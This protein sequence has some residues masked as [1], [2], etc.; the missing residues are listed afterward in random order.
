MSG[1]AIVSGAAPHALAAEWALRVGEA[2]EALQRLRREAAARAAHLGVPTPKLEAWKYT[3]LAAL[4]RTAW[5]AVVRLE[6]AGCPS[7]AVA[8]GAPDLTGTAPLFPE[9]VRV[10]SLARAFADDAD[11]VLAHLAQVASFADDYVAALN[12]AFLHDGIWIDVAPGVQ[13]DGAL[14]VVHRAPEGDAAPMT[15]GRVLITAGAGSSVAVC[16]RFVSDGAGAAFTTGVTEI[17]CG[18]NAQVEHT[19][20]VSENT[21]TI[22]LG[23]VAAR[24]ARDSRLISHAVSTGGALTRVE[25]ASRLAEPGAEATFNGLYLG[26][27]EQHVD[28]HTTLDHAA[29]HCTSAQTYRGVL[30]GRAHGVFNGAVIVRPD[31][32]K[33]DARQSNK[34]LLLSST[35]AIDTK[36]QLEIFANDVKCT[37]GATVGS[38]DEESLFYL[39]SRGI[40]RREAETLL[41]LAFANDIVQRISNEL[42]RELLAHALEAAFHGMDAAGDT[43]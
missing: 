4:G 36:P 39:R 18:A 16:E 31:A 21:A 15:H 37:H 40:P 10:R 41:T 8:G 2:P 32:Q 38:L 12:T 9:G 1:A 34:N 14:H 3:S 11:A 26:G 19:R 33:T 27:G 6:G 22:H 24:Q 13:V 23:V 43:A 42:Q 29:P 20:W 30:S 25:I 17:V 35:A 7:V 5:T 28:Y